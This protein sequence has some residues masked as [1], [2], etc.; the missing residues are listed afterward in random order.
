MANTFEGKPDTR[1]SDDVNLKVSRFRPNYRALT[2]EEKNFTMKLKV[3][4]KN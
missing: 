4:Q 1:Q 2:D 3:K